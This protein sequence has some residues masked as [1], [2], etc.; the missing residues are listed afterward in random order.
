MRLNLRKL[1][2]VFSLFFCGVFFIHRFPST[3]N[4]NEYSRIYQI[5]AIVET[6]HLYLDEIIKRYGHLM[7]K[8]HY[9]NHF[10]SDKSFGLTLA[11]LPV[12]AVY[13]SVFRL[14]IDNERLKYF[15]SIL[16]V[17]IA[18]IIFIYF[19]YAW[20]I[21][22]RAGRSF[23]EITLVAYM[24]GTIVFAYSALF[25]SH[26]AGAVTCAMAFMLI[27]K[28]APDNDFMFMPLLGLMLAMAVII[29][30]PLALICVWLMLYAGIYVW[31]QRKFKSVVLFFICFTLPI[32]VQLAVNY[33]SFGNPFS[34]GYANKSSVEQV[35]YHSHGLFGVGLPSWQ[36]FFGIIFSPSRGLFY[37]SPFLIFVIPVL[38][39]LV[40]NYKTRLQGIIIIG[41]LCTYTLFASSVFDWQAGW[42]VGP[43]YYL[44]VIPFMLI[45]LLKGENCMRPMFQGKHRV[46]TR[47]VYLVLIL[48]S[49]FH[50]VFITSAFPFVPEAVKNPFWEFSLPLLKKGYGSLSLFSLLGCPKTV[51]AVIFFILAVLLVF[52]VYCLKFSLFKKKNFVIPFVFSCLIACVLIISS[53]FLPPSDTLKKAVKMEYLYDHWE[54]PVDQLEQLYIIT[55]T[56]PSL[57][58][59][60]IKLADSLKKLG[61]YYQVGKHYKQILS[62]SP[63][64]SSARKRKNVIEAV[65]K[66]EEK[67]LNRIKTEKNSL[68][69]K[70]DLETAVIILIR[71]GEYEEAEQLMQNKLLR[72]K[73]T[74]KFLERVLPALKI[75]KKYDNIS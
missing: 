40:K 55:G 62:Q 29:E 27:E 14:P 30:F 28:Y 15:L 65:L 32:L 43:R 64:N 53:K 49:I 2:L 46:V 59:Y 22:N 1:F 7:D 13:H 68:N 74:D 70:N 57:F 35:F 61:F 12:Y 31:R 16:C 72:T 75:I 33:L 3:P 36:S 34:L 73:K 41:I 48:V 56:E 54:K 45:A 23:K 44:P 37:F 60:K 63:M 17:S 6:G 50:C 38:I 69:N 67:S 10:Y 4:P 47:V 9:K 19:L 24:L 21:E 20:Y 25:Y 18:N 5:R 71:H 42:T 51:S 11:A 58:D 52:F 26:V 66:S 8:S 39:C